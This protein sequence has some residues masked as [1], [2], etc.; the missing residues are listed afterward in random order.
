M[1]RRLFA[2]GEWIRTCSSAILIMLRK[3]GL[4]KTDQCTTEQ[5]VGRVPAYPALSS[6]PPV[7][8]NSVTSGQTIGVY[9]A[10]I[11]RICREIAL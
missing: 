9:A 10:K 3:T 1:V 4:S 6:K 5:G 11:S 8:S 7:D 2:G